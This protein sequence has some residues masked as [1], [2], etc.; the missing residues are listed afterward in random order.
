MDLDVALAFLV[1]L[2]PLVIAVAIAFAI[3]RRRAAGAA[4]GGEPIA[5]SVRRCYFYLAALIGLLVGA[6]G[7]YYIVRFALEGLFGELVIAASREPLAIGISLTVVGLAVWGI[8][9]RHIQR[10]LDRPA[11]AQAL[12]RSLYVYLVLAIAGVFLLVVAYEIVRWLLEIGRG[13]EF[14]PSAWSFAIVWGA[15]WVYHWHVGSAPVSAGPGAAAR[16]FYVYGSAAITLIIGATGVGMAVFAVVDAGYQAAFG[17]GDLLSTDARLW[18]DTMVSGLAL[19]LTGGAAW[20]THFLYFGAGSGDSALR[21]AYVFAAA[22]LGGYLLSMVAVTAVGVMLL[23]W[24]IGNPAE[25]TASHFAATPNWIATLVVGL[26]I[27]VYHRAILL[28]EVDESPLAAVSGS[29]VYTYSLAGFG[30]A[31]LSAAIGIATAHLAESLLRSDEGILVGAGSQLDPLATAIALAL[32]GAPVFLGYWR[33]AQQRAALPG[34][35]EQSAVARKVFVFSVLG[36]AA[37]VLTGSLSFLLYVLLNDVLAGVF[38]FEFLYEGRGAVG[39]TAATLPF[40]LYFWHINRNDR[41]LEPARAKPRRRLVTV[42]S[43]PGAEGIVADIE[44]TLGYRVET[45]AWAEAEGA[46]G[47]MEPEQLRELAERVSGAGGSRVLITL[48]SSGARVLSYGGRAGAD[49]G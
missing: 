11:E 49:G 20:G 32:V 26:A 46:A 45:F 42:L 12:L 5:V 7:V 31:A 30:L 18:G 41:E 19:A 24:L 1:L 40:L 16:R 13:G 39:A 9:W 25:E 22:L 3:S 27:W 35:E 28:R 36:A 6:G 29:R 21:Q 38:G 44:R 37:L 8:H 14:D 2:S 4:N 15:V 17:P 10:S 48:D 33:L 23:T 47:I 43:G 34:G